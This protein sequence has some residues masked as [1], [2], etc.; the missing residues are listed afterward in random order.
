MPDA[1]QVPVGETL[2]G[3]PATGVLPEAAWGRKSDEHNNW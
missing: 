2:A 1:P 3:T